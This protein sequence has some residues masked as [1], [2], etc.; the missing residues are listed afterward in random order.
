MGL[1]IAEALFMRL[2]CGPDSPEILL[3]EVNPVYGVKS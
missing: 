2:S 1:C 3:F